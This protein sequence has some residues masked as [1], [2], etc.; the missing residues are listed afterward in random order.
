M[1]N[2]LSEWNMNLVMSGWRKKWKKASFYPDGGNK[3]LVLKGVKISKAI[4][5]SFTCVPLMG[6]I[7]GVSK[8]NKTSRIKDYSF[9]KSNKQK[10]NKM[11]V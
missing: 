5:A 6:E 7:I 11:H 3:C 9:L 10:E 1:L 8:S 2:Y 4:M